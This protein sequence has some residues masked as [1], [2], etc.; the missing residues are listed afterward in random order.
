MVKLLVCDK[1]ELS[2]INLSYVKSRICV[3]YAISIGHTVKPVENGHSKI[4]KMKVSK[5]NGSLMRS[6]VLQN[7]LLEHSAIL[8]T[9]I[10]Q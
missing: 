6:K 8:L 7:A 5:T 1:A 3:M 10:K 9:C 2:Y 4:D